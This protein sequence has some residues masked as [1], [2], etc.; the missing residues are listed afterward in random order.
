M[1]NSSVIGHSEQQSQAGQALVESL[2]AISVF[3][4]IWVAVH[5]LGNYQDM[6]LSATHA[7]RHIAF[8]GTRTSATGADSP[9]SESAVAVVSDRYFGGSAHRW[10]KLQ[11]A[12]LLDRRSSIS[13]AWSRDHQLP[14][15]AQ[16]GLTTP[17]GKTLRREWTLDDAGVLRASVHLHP[18]DSD[19]RR[20]EKQSLM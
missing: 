5:W 13:L 15:L 4:L 3:A 20:M 16:P 7:S 19:S 8:L 6:S 14:D 10:L 2:V 12:A 17:T 9:L 18:M 11:G 1:A